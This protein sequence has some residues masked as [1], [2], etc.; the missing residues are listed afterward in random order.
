MNT[1]DLMEGGILILRRKALSRFRYF[2]LSFVSRHATTREVQ[3]EQPP[4]LPREDDITLAGD[5][6]H[7]VDVLAVRP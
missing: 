3:V 4:G 2:V 7:P 5:R 6:F 1:A